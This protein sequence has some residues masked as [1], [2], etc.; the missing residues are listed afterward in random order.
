MPDILYKS[1]SLEKNKSSISGSLSLWE[2][3]PVSPFDV[4]DT[5][6]PI[7]NG[8]LLTVE[9]VSIKDNVIGVSNGKLLR[10]WEITVEGSNSPSGS[11]I[12]RVKY[13]FSISHE[14]KSGSMEVFCTGEAPAISLNVGDTFF[15][16]GIGEVFCSS[17]K[18]NDSY[19]EAGIHSWS[20]IYEGSNKTVIQEAEVKYS[21]N[22]EHN[23]DGLTVY[24]GSKEFTCSGIAPVVDVHIGDTFTL[25]LIGELT[26]TRISSSNIDANSWS[27]S[28]EGSRGGSSSGDGEDDDSSL[29]END[30]VITREINGST[31][32][33]VNGEVI[34]LR[35][36]LSPIVK[37]TIT[38][39]TS[40]VDALATPGNLYQGGI[41]LSENIIKETIKNN[42]VV[43]N[44][45]YKHTLEVEA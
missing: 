15:I 25:P 23:S 32:R 35:R 6:K 9:K 16:P 42:G 10:Q 34:A 14:E 38:V 2:D 5:F 27:V 24:S 19:D 7:S 13:N 11:S 31:V 21:L 3:S 22:I 18:G 39:Y 29:P 40:T 28:I 4:G 12:T 26:C 30:T 33:T 44:S 45:Y 1:H 8:P 41:V 43:T 36:S 20:I 17:V 37:K